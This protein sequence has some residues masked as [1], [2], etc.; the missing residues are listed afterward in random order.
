VEYFLLPLIAFLAFLLKAMTGFGPAIIV[1]AFCSLFI[2]P[3]KVIAMS[4]VL[5]AVAGG[6]LLRTDWSRGGF[7]FWGPLAVAIVLGAVIGG[8]FLNMIPP[9]YFRLLLGTAIFLLGL[10]FLI[11]RP[12][13]AEDRL[14]NALPDQSSR[15][16]VSV[17]LLGGVC[18]GL[19]GISGPPIIWHFGRRFAKRAF[20]QILVPI[21]LAAALARIITYASLGIMDRQVLYYVL[22]SIPGLLPGIYFGNKIFSS[23]SEMTFRRIAGAVLLL[24][25]AQQVI[26]FF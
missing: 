17:S 1:I 13:R 23:A 18:G 24:I 20:R 9:S 6:I 25:A 12:D 3:H 7:R 21:F 16:D 19:F 15:A 14:L 5:D 11:G 10:W 22:I 8:I 4:A 2:A 26:S